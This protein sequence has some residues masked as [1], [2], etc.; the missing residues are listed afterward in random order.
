MDIELIK[1]SLDDI[2]QVRAWRNSPNVAPYMYNEREISP[3][4]QR[5]WFNSINEEKSR[6]WLISYN[7]KKIGLASVTG[8]DHTLQSCYWAFYLG[9]SAVRGA[10]IG[11]KVE[12]NVLEY[13]FNEL[14]LNKLRCEVFVDND[15]VIKMHEKFGFRR[16][17]YYREH[18]VK[19]GKK[20]DVVGLAILK[21][22]WDRLKSFQKKAIYGE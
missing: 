2:E 16:E 7:E 20:L 8:I 6:Y 13:V 14:K 10:G 21:S 19:A 9:D 4:D 3:S 17:A 12:Y 22:E 1:L 5:N 15:K 18:C 11:A